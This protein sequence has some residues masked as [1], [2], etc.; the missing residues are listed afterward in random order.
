MSTRSTISAPKLHGIWG[1][2]AC[3]ARLR[4]MAQQDADLDGIWAADSAR[5]R[6]DEYAD[7]VRFVLDGILPADRQID[8]PEAT[9]A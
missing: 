4:Y 5:D 2:D 7:L 6:C 9:D 8:R 3:L 1:R